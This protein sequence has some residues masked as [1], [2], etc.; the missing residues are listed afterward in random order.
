M[1]TGSGFLIGADGQFYT[2]SGWDSVTASKHRSEEFIPMRSTGLTDK[3]A[4]EIFESDW[5]KNEKGRICEVIYVKELARWDERFEADTNYVEGVDMADGFEP[6][7]WEHCVEVI[8]NR[9]ENP[10]PLEI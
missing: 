5:I 1:Q 8:G 7:L 9:H 10:W 2:D 3:N 6:R 4:V